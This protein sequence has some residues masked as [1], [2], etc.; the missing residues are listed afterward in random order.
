MALTQYVIERRFPA[1]PAELYRA[2]ADPQMF[3]RWVWG[4]N[5][6]GVLA[7]IDLRIN[8]TLQVSIEANGA[9]KP[10]M[11]GIY[12]VIETGRRL[13]HTVHWDGDVGYNAPGRNPLDEVQVIDFLPDAA[14]SLLRYLHMGI[15]D[16]GKSA[17]GHEQSVRATFDGL[18]KLLRGEVRAPG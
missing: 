17:A 16:D 3:A 4:I 7:E 14:G 8:G 13:I 2:F 1:P 6:K 5:T 15:P 10:A 12:L 9:R 11:R 18:D